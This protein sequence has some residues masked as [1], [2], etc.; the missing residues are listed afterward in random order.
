MPG[1]ADY[2][3]LVAVGPKASSE[4]VS[5]QMRAMPRRDTGPELALRRSVHRRGMRYVLG[6][7]GLPGRPDL[8][9][10]RRRI[11]VFV[12]GCFW[13]GCP[14]HGVRPRANAEWWAAKL[15]ANTARDRRN[16]RDLIEAGWAVVHVWEHEDPDEAAGALHRLWTERA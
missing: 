15:D 6:G 9:F 5:R 2:T 13:H 12:D 11:A 14:T 7:A 16:D 1:L 10:S 8:V 3:I 4:A